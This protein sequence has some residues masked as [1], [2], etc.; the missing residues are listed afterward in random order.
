MVTP[1]WWPVRCRIPQ[2][3]IFGIVLFHVLLNDLDVGLDCVQSKKS[4]DDSNCRG[5]AELL[6]IRESLQRAHDR[7]EG[8]NIS[9]GMKLNKSKFWILHLGPGYPGEKRIW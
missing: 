9:N 3:S 5:A 8:W 6:R 7:P 1:G 4:V 2:S